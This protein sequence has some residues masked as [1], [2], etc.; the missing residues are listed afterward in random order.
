SKGDFEQSLDWSQFGFDGYVLLDDVTLQAA[1]FAMPVTGLNGG[2]WVEGNRLLYP[3]LR[4][5]VG[6]SRFSLS[7][8]SSI[9]SA[10]RGQGSLA[11]AFSSETPWSV[12]AQIE[13]DRFHEKILPEKGR[14]APRENMRDEADFL[15]SLRDFVRSA[16]AQKS[17]L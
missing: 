11:A 1:M 8:E 10:K 3:N 15:N 6:E 9:V 5:S 16:R 4:F 12:T 17:R 7:G 14:R 13:V 2:L